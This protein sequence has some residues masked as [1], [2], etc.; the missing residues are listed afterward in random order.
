MAFEPTELV[1]HQLSITVSL[2]G[3]RPMMREMLAFAQERGVKPKVELMLMS[4]VNEAI[5][6]VKEG[7]ARYRI[8]LIN[9]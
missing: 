7:K 6:K 4:Q 5:R 9:D 3:S 2:L 1:V 8:V